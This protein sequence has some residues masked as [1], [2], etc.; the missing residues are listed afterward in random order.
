MKITD[1][2][3]TADAVRSYSEYHQQ[4]TEFRF[5]VD[6][7]SIQTQDR[8]NISAEA[9]ACTPGRED[10]GALGDEC[11]PA[12]TIERLITEV[13]SGKKIRVLRLEELRGDN[14]DAA[15]GDAGDL[16]GSPSASQGWGLDYSH[17]EEYAERETVT[18]DARGVVTTSDGRRLAFTLHL[19]MDREYVERSEV[20]IRAGD[21]LKDPL[22][23]N[24][25]GSAVSL[26]G[27]RYAFDLD[28][29]GVEESIP[30][31]APGKGYLALDLD[32]NGVIDD[33]RELFGP[34]TGDGFSELSALDEDKNGW[35][36]EADKAFGMLRV[37]SF[38]G[39]GAR[40]V[41]SLADVGVGALSTGSLPTPFDMK[42]PVTGERHG[43]VR[44]TG[45]YIAENGAVGTLQQLDLVV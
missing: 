15:P 44:A 2:I 25:D 28:G 21:A 39:S 30:G 11:E 38:D 22:V 34:S 26:A 10:E 32:A 40:V 36:D 12:V 33:G 23:I 1:S 20:R 35:I 19:E 45:L 4:R 14:P 3:V 43:R 18:F 29:D 27:S 5:W 37:M 8:V 6:R 9:Y 42:D 17:T 31:L 41:S 13:L 7:P 24:L 16:D